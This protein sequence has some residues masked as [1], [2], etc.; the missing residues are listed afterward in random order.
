M[1]T[2]ENKIRII[3]LIL[4]SVMLLASCDAGQVVSDR[5]DALLNSGVMAASYPVTTLRRSPYCEPSE[6]VEEL[7][8]E[9]IISPDAPHIIE[10]EP[11]VMDYHVGDRFSR[12]LIT[13]NN[14]AYEVPAD[15]QEKYC[16]KVLEDAIE[17]EYAVTFYAVDLETGASFGYNADDKIS[18][19]CTLK[20]GVA[21]YCMREIRSGRVSYDDMVVYE[22]RHYVAGTGN[23]RRRGYGAEVSVKELLEL[24]LVESDNIAYYMLI[25]YLGYDGYN[26]LMKEYGVSHEIYEGSRW[27]RMSSHD[28]GLLW[29]ETYRFRDTCEEGQFLWELVTHNKYNFLDHALN[30]YTAHG[31]ETIAHKSGYSSSA[32][33]DA[34]VVMAEHPYVIVYMTAI[35]ARTYPFIDGVV[36]VDKLL[37]QYR[38]W[39]SENGDPGLHTD[40]NTASGETV[41]HSENTEPETAQILGP[42]Q[43]REPA[44][45]EPVIEVPEETSPAEI[46]PVVEPP[47]ETYP[48]ETYPQET[49][50]AETEPAAEVPEETVYTVYEEEIPGDAYT[51]ET[52]PAE[53][54][55]EEEIPTE[56]PGQID[57]PSEAPSD[58]SAEDITVAETDAETDSE[59]TYP[60]EEGIYLQ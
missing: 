52:D 15:M 18:P 1:N 41:S 57:E 55:Y 54:A 42:R 10:L 43:D 28:L 11:V 50:P 53:A 48:Q 6:T 56:D 35:D 2:S 24:M 33:N 20:I 60:E 32:F 44:Q 4:C 58:D 7:S 59:E 37:R 46:P 8:E 16:T 51:D 5:F 29:L 25:D 49:A 19:A 39:Y 23:I 38:D 22:R 34:G 26:S 14:S 27:S 40:D 36:F 13:V 12:D 45:P 9:D 31:Y 21:L 3:A 17:G 47:K 30:E